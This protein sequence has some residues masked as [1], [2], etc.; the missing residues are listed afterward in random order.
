[1]KDWIA[2]VGALLVLGPLAACN[3]EPPVETGPR[4]TQV[5][6]G[7]VHD[8]RT[9]L[10]WER[11][12]GTGGLHD[13]AATYTWFSPDRRVNMSEPGT[14]AGGRCALDTCDTESFVAA[15]NAAGLC[16][17]HDWRMPAHEETITL[18]VSRGGP[19]GNA[20]DPDHFHDTPPAEFWT[21][22]TFRMYPDSAWAF[23][24]RTG[25]DRADLKSVAK[26]VRLVRGPVEIGTG[27]AP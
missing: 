27:D 6:G 16:G 5:A 3:Q 23:D 18:A 13:A 7:C 9:G 22:T 19:H 21:G 24:T 4:F 12:S 14:R 26:P 11:K 25:L 8:R 2:G 15:V 20:L 10:V 17:W 1:M